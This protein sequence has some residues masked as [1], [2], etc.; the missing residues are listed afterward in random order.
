MRSLLN[1]E[2]EKSERLA[3]IKS[4]LDLEGVKPSPEPTPLPEV[5]PSEIRLVAWMAVQKA[6]QQVN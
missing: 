1:E 4:L 6:K 2:M 3:R 5:N